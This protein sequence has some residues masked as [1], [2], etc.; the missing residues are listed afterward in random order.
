MTICHDCLPSKLVTLSFITVRNEENFSASELNSD[1]NFFRHGFKSYLLAF[2]MQSFFLKEKVVI[3][4][5]VSITSHQVLSVKFPL[6]V[7]DYGDNKFTPNLVGNNHF[8][9]FFSVNIAIIC[10]LP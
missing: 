6:N 5:F 4:I 1:T 10:L 7:W 8:I 3:K 9:I 2:W